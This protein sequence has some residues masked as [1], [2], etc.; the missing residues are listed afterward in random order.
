MS[1][2]ESS[3]LSEVEYQANTTSGTGTT[4]AEIHPAPSN[5][6]EALELILTLKKCSK[7]R[8]ISLSHQLGDFK[9]NIG[10]A[11]SQII[12]KQDL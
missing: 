6:E 3:L 12:F 7:G 10:V 9:N 4:A 1:S 11:V 8:R 5:T 2:T